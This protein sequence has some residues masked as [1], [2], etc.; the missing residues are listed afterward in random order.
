MYMYMCT[1]FTCIKVG[2]LWQGSGAFLNYLGLLSAGGFLFSTDNLSIACMLHAWQLYI[3]YTHWLPTIQ[4]KGPLGGVPTN[5]CH[6]LCVPHTTNPWTSLLSAD[7]AVLLVLDNVQGIPIV[8]YNAI[9]VGG[10]PVAACRRWL[11]CYFQ[12]RGCFEWGTD[13]HR[14]DMGLVIAC[15]ILI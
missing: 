2:I 10:I 12:Q 14:G 15:S 11:L 7:V 4:N 3:Q 8:Q 5:P 9:M 13:M 1:H 6:F